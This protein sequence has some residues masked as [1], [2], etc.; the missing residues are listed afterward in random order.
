MLKC[1]PKVKNA[2]LIWLSSCLKYNSSR[3][4]IWNMHAPELNPDIY[5]NVTDGFMINMCN[6]LLRLCHP[7]CSK[8]EDERMLRVDPT[9]AAV[10][11]SEIFSINSYNKLLP[12]FYFHLWLWI[13]FISSVIRENH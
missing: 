1:S 5:T 10:P 8:I 6:L 13:H 12:N 11:V 2:T 9:Y 4:K 3:G 7:F